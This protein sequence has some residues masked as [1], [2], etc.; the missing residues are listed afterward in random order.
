MTVEEKSRQEY[1]DRVRAQNEAQD[2]AL[3]AFA[4][5][6]RAAYPNAVVDCRNS[7]K[8]KA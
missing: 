4:D 3:R 7:H 2:L 8:E 5:R 1:H 6:L